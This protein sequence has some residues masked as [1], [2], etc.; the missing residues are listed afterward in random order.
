MIT[1]KQVEAFYWVGTLGSF[2]AASNRLNVAQS[3]VSKRIQ[4]LEWSLKAPLFNR[5]KRGGGLT[6][7]GVEMLEMAGEM[8]SIQERIEAAAVGG[9]LLRGPVHIGVTEFASV[10]WLSEVLSSVRALYPSL[11]L[12]IH[13]EPETAIAEH[14]ADGALDL[15]IAPVLDDD[16]GAEEVELEDIEMRWMCAPHFNTGREPLPAVRLRDLPLLVEP[17]AGVPAGRPHCA[18]SRR[19]RPGCSVSCNGMAARARLAEAGLGLACLPRRL[20]EDEIATGRLR[21][22]DVDPVP[23]AL[24]YVAAYRADAPGAVTAEIAQVTREI[25]LR[26]RDMTTRLTASRAPK[27]AR[28]I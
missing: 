22:V 27:F 1:I 24:S 12:S 23:P 2:S 19:A 7:R 16:G 14:F 18:R 3:T 11:S 25:A 10:V 13:V 28:L 17:A 8:L 9:P 20:F 5:D 6:T 21:I 4:E 26:A 15:V